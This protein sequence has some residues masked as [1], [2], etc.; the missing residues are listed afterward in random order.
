[1]LS[2]VV[3]AHIHCCPLW[4]FPFGLSL[5]ALMRPI[6]VVPSCNGP[7]P[8][9]SSLAFPFRAFPQGFKTGRF[10]H[11]YKWWFVLLINQCGTSQPTL[12]RDPAVC[13]P[14]QPMWDITIHP[15]SGPSGL[16]SSSTNVGHRNP[17]SFGAQ[18]S[19]LLTLFPFSI[20]VGPPPNPPPFG[21]S[22]AFLLALFPSS[23][24]CGTAPKSTPIW[25]PASLLAHCLVPTPLRG[26]AR[27]LAHHPVSSSDTICNVPDP[28]LADIVLFRLFP[29]GF[30]SRL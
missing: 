16:F 23:N 5:K 9:M 13:S 1:M 7:Y 2:L 3:T 27:R 28:P 30:P 6:R 26:T 22:P 21:A 17:P 20:D 29:S 4:P 14:L 18:P 15:P 12:L 19:V 24:Q 10:P 8:P 11:S 25:G